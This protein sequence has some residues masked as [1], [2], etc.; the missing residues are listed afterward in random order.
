MA[1]PSNR[2]AIIEAAIRVAARDPITTVTIDAVAAEAGLTK[3]GVLYHF[4][5]KNELLVAVQEQ[6][7]AEWEAQLEAAAGGTADETPLPR[8]VAVY[9]RVSAEAASRAELML[10]LE[11]ISAPEIAAPIRAVIDRWVP[12]VDAALRD[13]EL[14]PFVLARLAAD[15]LWFGDTDKDLPPEQLARIADAIAAIAEPDAPDAPRG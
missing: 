6:L 15:G 9:A 7:A 12:S 13:P 8:R 10:M 5:S 3:A 14:W 1:R 2:A 4:P 11:A